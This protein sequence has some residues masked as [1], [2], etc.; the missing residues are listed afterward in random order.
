MACS[1]V[2]QTK[3]AKR[4][5]LNVFRLGLNEYRGFLVT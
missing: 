4:L 5:L 3:P 2:K 1:D